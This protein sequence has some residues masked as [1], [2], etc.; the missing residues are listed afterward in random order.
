MD[1]IKNPRC[2]VVRD[3]LLPLNVLQ[4]EYNGQC[5]NARIFINIFRHFIRDSRE[6]K[7][8]SKG[9]IGA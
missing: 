3:I 6:G 5:P 7:R 1:I 4:E 2:T 8:K 9:K